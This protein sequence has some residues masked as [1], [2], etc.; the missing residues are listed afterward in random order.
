M[1]EIQTIPDAKGSA[2]PRIVGQ[3]DRYFTE[4]FEIFKADKNCVMI[5][6]DNGAPTLDQFAEQLPKQFIQVG[7]AE[8]QMFGMAA[9]L[10]VEGKKVFCYAI[11][12]FV[13]TRVH[14]FI[15]LDVCAMDLPIVLLGVGAGYAY[16][17]MGPSHHTVED[18]S[19]MRAL[20]NLVIWS[21]C[22]G[23]T[24]AALA[25]RSYELS[26]PQYI[27]FDRA[28]VA[29]VYDEAP[30]L[31]RGF[32][33]VGGNVDGDSRSDVD[34]LATSAMVDNA[35]KVAAL[36]GDKVRVRV[37][38]VFRLKPILSAELLAHLQDADHVVTLEEHFLN[39]G[40][41]SIVA[42]IFADNHVKTP[43]YRMGIPDEFVFDY[44][45]RENI[46]KRFG[47]DTESV[48][49]AIRTY[50]GSSSRVTPCLR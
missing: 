47:L 41:G 39:G 20:P 9:G 18:I 30:N 31:V 1:A 4:L 32:Q 45:G 48:S 38:D 19:I 3:R 24:A 11:A 46:W 26:S 14:E 40:L 49:S 28:G 27:R 12:P 37:V 6:A 33:V 25:R 7:I 10:A 50:C 16:D 2:T 34:I 42:E 23:P 21:P 22:D 29:D 5:T 17:V 44:G 36:L 35:C 43:L 13:T 8:Q 15:K